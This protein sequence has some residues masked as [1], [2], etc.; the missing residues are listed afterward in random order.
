MATETQTVADRFAIK[1]GV[2]QR[3]RLRELLGYAAALALCLLILVWAMGLRREAVRMPFTYQGDT[4]F[5]HLLVKGMVDHGWF[6]D[7]PSL[8][9]PRTLDLR[10]APSTDNNF[11]F[12]LLKLIS[13]A[14]PSYPQV[15]NAFFLLSFPLTTLSA[16]FVLRQ[17]GISRLTAI[18][19]SLIYTF[20]PFHFTRGQH[21]LFLSAYYFVPLA[22]M[23]ALWIC[24]DELSLGKWRDPKLAGS[25]VICL[26]IASS[27]YYYA[28]FSCF[29]LLVAGLVAAL[30]Q[31]SARAIGLPCCLA[32]LI[33]AGVAANM[34]PSVE[35]FSDQGSVHFVRRL[36]GEADIYGLR[37]AQLLLPVRWHRLESLSDLKVDYNMRL[38]I[39]E[40]DDASLGIIGSLGFL[41]LLWWLFFKKPELKLLNVEHTSGLLNH[42]SLLNGAA[43]LLGTIGG[44]GSLVAFF[45]LPQVRAYNRVS[46]FIAFFSLLAV[47]LW[48]DRLSDRYLQSRAKQLAFGA[49]LAVALTLGLLDQISPRFLPDYRRAEDEYMSDE[50]FVKKI[51]AAL[52]EGSMIF[53]LPVVSFPENPKVNK[54]SD[55]DPVR[56]YLHSNKLRWSYGTIKGREGDVWSRGVAAKSTAEMVETL[57]WAGFSGVYIDRFGFSDNGA[58][59]ESELSSVLSVAPLVS[60]NDRLV[61]FDLTGDQRE[62]K[63]RHPQQEWETR[64]EAALHPIIAVWQTGFSDLEFGQDNRSW[65]WCGAEGV[66]KLVNSTSKDQEVK[67]EMILAAD[68]GGTVEIQSQFFNEKLK[69]DWKGQQFSRTFAMPPGQHAIRFASDARRILPPND[70]RELVFR[71]INF[72]MTPAR[73]A[74]EEAT[75]EVIEEKK[76]RAA[77]AR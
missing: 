19:A 56:G 31:R 9:A 23:I 58:R 15:L 33:F 55:Y 50:V 41:G 6:L 26:L 52:P 38:L 22:V 70:F 74:T 73:A 45:G 63:E 59:I 14:K 57:A 75:E 11:Y 54:M 36:S 7:N 24:R 5:Y 16:L 42:L 3:P 46:I 2:L 43:L 4:M 28:F 44:L 1:L 47:A 8:A 30:R 61:F 66:M 39:N 51:E 76:A 64:R 69:V 12:V 68:N 40:N 32:A 21:H 72:E 18:F 35:R 65:H 13:L 17:F 62:L 71:V 34:L 67:L 20:L 53:Q 48:L 10:D 77:G 60:P 49:L 37:I 27:G 25:V 29:F